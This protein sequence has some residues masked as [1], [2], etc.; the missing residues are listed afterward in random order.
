MLTTSPDLDWAQKSN[1]GRGRMGVMDGWWWVSLCVC[2]YVHVLVCHFG[3]VLTICVPGVCDVIRMCMCVWGDIIYLSIYLSTY[4]PICLSLYLSICLSIYL[5][6]NLSMYLSIYL[7]YLIHLIHLID[8]ID[9]IYLFIFLCHA[10]ATQKPPAERRRPRDAR[11][12]IR[13]LAE[14]QVPR[15]P[16]NSHVSEWVSEGSEGVRE[17]GSEGVREWVS[18]CVC[19]CVICVSAVCVREDR[20][21]EGGGRGRRKKKKA[22]RI[23][24]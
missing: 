14:H 18:E 19:V 4:L 10:P 13:P 2:M 20:R 9:L 17:W 23:Q 5:S 22:E 11:A 21:Q 15:L 8:L 16:R 6:I 12:Y 1:K 7:I 24:N 3:S